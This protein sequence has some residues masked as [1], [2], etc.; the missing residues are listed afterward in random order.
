M[1]IGSQF[2]GHL[3][4]G[5]QR[6]RN[7]FRQTD[8]L[9]QTRCNAAGKGGATTSQQR[10]TSPERVAGRGVRIAGKRIEEEIGKPLARNKIYREAWGYEMLAGDR[11][12]DVFVRKLRQKLDKASP[13]W[14]SAR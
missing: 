11:S 6:R 8:R 4:I 5:L 12:V 10:D 3:H 9:E 14:R 7:Q 1:A 2:D 13:G